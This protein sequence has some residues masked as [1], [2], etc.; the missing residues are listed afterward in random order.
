MII[1]QGFPVAQAANN[2]IKQHFSNDSKLVKAMIW[3]VYQSAAEWGY[4]R[5]YEAAVKTMK[6]TGRIK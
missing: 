4:M 6:R 2:Y 1:K 3:R 5:G